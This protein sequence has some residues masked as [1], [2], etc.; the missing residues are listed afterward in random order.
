GK[1]CFTS[2]SEN[3]VKQYFPEPAVLR[4][5]FTVA[6]TLFAVRITRD[7]APARPEDVRFFRVENRDGSPVAQIY[8]DLYARE[9][10]RGA[11]WMDDA[12][13]P[14]KLGDGRVPAPV[15]YLPV[16]FSAAIVGQPA[17]VNHDA[18]IHLVPAFGHG[19]EHFRRPG[20]LL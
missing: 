10:K 9:G 20:A 6:A 19:P 5:L 2:F 16:I 8:L 18:G 12:R 11:A 13:S 15:P 17:C 14:A 3:D 1:Y 4:G 7:D